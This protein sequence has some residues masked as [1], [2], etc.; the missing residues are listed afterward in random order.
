MINRLLC[1]CVLCCATAAT[2]QKQ[3][4]PDHILRIYKASDPNLDTKLELEK[5]MGVYLTHPPRRHH[6]EKIQLKG[7]HVFVDIWQSVYGLSDSELQC[8]ALKWLVYGRT[9]YVQ[10]ARQVL[11]EK[12]EFNRV[13]IRFNDVE[14]SKD[15]RRVKK[16]QEKIVRYLQATL[17]RPVM[18]RLNVK[19]LESI[20]DSGECSRAFGRTFK[21]RLKKRYTKRRRASR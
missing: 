9:Q 10:G 19:N 16:G 2:A 15:S 18:N 3:T 13:T 17:S 12:T 6:S 7:D 21:G 1:I 8:R 5:M 11:S 4:F 20:I 14:H